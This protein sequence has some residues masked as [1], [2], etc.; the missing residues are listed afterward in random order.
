M[1]SDT[2]DLEGERRRPT[3]RERCRGTAAAIGCPLQPLCKGRGMVR[4]LRC[5]QPYRRGP[6]FFSARALPASSFSCVFL[7]AAPRALFLPP[8][9]IARRALPGS[10][11]AR[12]WLGPSSAPSH[13]PCHGRAPQLVSFKHAALLPARPWVP[14]QPP[15]TST[16]VGSPRPRRGGSVVAPSSSSWPA[17]FPWPALAPTPARPARPVSRALLV[18]MAAI[19]CSPSSSVAVQLTGVCLAAVQPLGFIFPLLLSADAFSVPQSMAPGRPS[20]R[21]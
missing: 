3:H 15:L 17:S 19:P 9:R 11:R 18:S 14:N 2:L 21:P 10:A 12:P 7:S 6:D 20:P 1:N 8:L 16:R 5:A 4:E 13:L